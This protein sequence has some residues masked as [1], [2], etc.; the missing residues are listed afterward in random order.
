MSKVI[1]QLNLDDSSIGD[2][3]EGIGKSSE[4]KFAEIGEKL[5]ESFSNSF[6][7]VAVNSDG[8]FDNLFKKTNKLGDYFKMATSVFA[9]NVLFAAVSSITNAFGSLIGSVGNSIK[10]FSEQEDAINK[11]SQSLRANNSFSEQAID[12]FI[13]FASLMESTT[14]YGDELI[15]SQVAIAKSF[16]ATNK[17]AEDL[18]LAAANLAAAFGGT[19]EENVFK[20]SQ[21]L[22]GEIG[23]LGKLVPELKALTKEQLASGEAARIINERFSGAAR[24]EIESYSG[25]LV[26]LTN[27]MSNLAEEVGGFIV[28]TFRLR[29]LNKFLADGFQN[30]TNKVLGLKESFQRGS[31]GFREN[32]GSVT[33]LSERYAKLT[34][35]IEKQ[36]SIIK[37]LRE[38][39]KF[40]VRAAGDIVMAKDKVAVLTRE[41][42]KI[43]E[44]VN[45]FT[46]AASG[47]SEVIRKSASLSI[48]DLDSLRTKLFELKNE[49][50][51]FGLTDIEVIR[52]KELEALDILQESFANKLLSEQEYLNLKYQINESANQRIK[53]LEEKSNAE[54]LASVRA[55]NQIIV[56]A[57]TN[58]ISQGIQRV[59]TSL[60]KGQ[61]IFE[62]FGTW[63]VQLFGDLAIQLGQFY[64]AQGLAQLA[65][66]S[67]NPA[68]TISTGAAL[69][70][71]GALLKGFFA[72]GLGGGSKV[73]A[74]G[75]QPG[76]GQ[77]TTPT[78]LAKPEDIDQERQAPKTNVQV[79]VQG[80][81]VQQ[82]E[83]GEFIT[84][85]LNESFGKQ[86][87]TLT[88]ARFA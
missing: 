74:V 28:D 35:E 84:R 2:S 31:E 22:N 68:A 82:E 36:E 63:I 13:Q 59:A 80:S 23:R 32:E 37:S 1:I 18:V 34:E 26:V 62:G 43:F 38:E 50:K 70:A 7:A 51:F 76:P 4:K 9:G 75:A 12:N 85:T 48:A 65:L 47:P 79:V 67:A 17:Q 81:L 30:L 16:G 27:S 21:T 72:G 40:S 53:D 44:Q 3:L 25:S 71:L 10:A 55:A 11:L 49:F 5:N 83:L 78:D 88:D 66:L 15:L 41:Y 56:N 8:L 46:M 24:S 33:R 61:S 6:K 29:D 14:K 20:L 39:A 60:A 19:L 87:V 86:G 45:S 69:I 73:A 42:E 52:Q 57:M 64:V 58:A 77:F 54:R